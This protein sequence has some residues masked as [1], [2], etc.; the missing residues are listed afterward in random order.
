MKAERV[1]AGMTQAELAKRIADEFEIKLDTS[2]ITRIEAGD[3]EPRLSEA[4]AIAEILGLELAPSPAESDLEP[5]LRTVSDQLYES[6]ERLLML[7]D[8]VDEMT[9]VA[10]RTTDANHLRELI[11][12]ELDGFSSHTGS[13]GD[14]AEN[15]STRG[16]NKARDRADYQL[17]RRFLKTLSEAVLSGPE[18]SPSPEAK[19]KWD[20]LYDRLLA[21]VAAHGDASV[22]RLYVQED[23]LA[24]GQWVAAQRNGYVHGLLNRE[25]L[26]RLESLPGWTWTRGPRHRETPR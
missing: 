1:H 21:Y 13:A 5:Y 8:T 7:L 23:G 12:E 11:S 3:R 15:R 19:A 14:D 16:V 25:A 26:E 22:P 10:R 4:L 17:K 2:G 20:E 18:D 6:R 9:N 24:L